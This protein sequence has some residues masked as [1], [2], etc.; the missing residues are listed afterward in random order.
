MYAG[1]RLLAAERLYLDVWDHKGPLVHHVNA[2][3]AVSA[4]HRLGVWWLRLGWLVLT[5]VLAATLLTRRYSPP[6]T[7]AGAA[8]AFAPL[9]LLAEGGNM[10]EE[11]ALLTSWASL[12][13]VAAPARQGGGV[14]S[15]AVGVLSGASFALRPNLVATPAAVFGVLLMQG[16]GRIERL[17]PFSCGMALI[18]GALALA[19]GGLEGVQAC[20]DAVWVYNRAYVAAGKPLAMD[21][22]WD[23]EGPARW[24]FGVVLAAW[25]A[26]ALRLRRAPRTED[27]LRLAALLAFPVEVV[28]VSLSGRAYLHYLLALTP[29]AGVLFAASVADFM[30]QDRS[31][32]PQG[33]WG[34]GLG[35]ALALFTAAA[36][37]RAPFALLAHSFRGHKVA[38]RASSLARA[39]ELT[40]LGTE[41][42]RLWV[43]GAE[44]SALVLSRRVSPVRY[45]YAYPL[46][47]RGYA[48]PTRV[49]EVKGGLC[50]RR[51]EIL[52]ASFNNPNIPPVRREARDAWRA[53]HPS[54]FVSDS[55][56]ELLQFVATYWR[57]GD[58]LPHTGFVRWYPPPADSLDFTLECAK[59]P[60]GVN[61]KK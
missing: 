22:W 41:G 32:S 43:W 51:P 36:M 47:T 21:T 40:Q 54:Y 29:V 13:C 61:P 15:L 52:E 3:A 28:A 24:F 27:P 37:T 55:V 38:E 50:R 46:L 34:T 60:Q 53:S 23:L 42:G 48:S 10:V 33:T 16:R 59:L 44:S 30:R 49:E 18:G 25:V 19:L 12:A 8:V 45:Y 35:V 20:W 56:D 31:A 57:E 26:S 17:I 4:D 5:A 39:A 9:A 2:L 58:R 6:A 1:Q 14:R 11:Y 7:V